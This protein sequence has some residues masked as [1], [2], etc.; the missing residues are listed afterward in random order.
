MRS[1]QQ[2]EFSI[3]KCHIGFLLQFDPTN[4]FV[5]LHFFRFRKLLF[6][7]Q[8]S[9]VF[10]FFIQTTIFYTNLKLHKFSEEKIEK[11]R[12]LS[13]SQS[14]QTIKENRR[15]VERLKKSEAKRAKLCKLNPFVYPG[16]NG[17]QKVS[18]FQILISEVPLDLHQRLIVFSNSK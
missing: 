2:V 10:I 7:P 11:R 15:V 1:A 4:I 13:W 6:I 17:K 14:G 5:F 12:N 8:L 18:I 9:E 3:F 16:K